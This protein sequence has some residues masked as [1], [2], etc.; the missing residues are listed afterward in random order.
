VVALLAERRGFFA[1]SN[2]IIHG[3][4]AMRQLGAGK[5]PG[6]A[7]RLKKKVTG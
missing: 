1:D 3:R 5:Y 4:R 6:A 2:N 7:T